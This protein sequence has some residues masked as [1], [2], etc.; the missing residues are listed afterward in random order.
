MMQ[1]QPANTSP[2]MQPTL[3]R[4][5]TDQADAQQVVG[6]LSDVM[7][8]LLQLVQEETHLVRLGRLTEVSRLAE[9]K[10]KLARL[11][12][13][14][15]ARLQASQ[16]YLAKTVPA[17][18]RILH[19]RHNTFRGMLQIN[20]TVLA[21]AHAVAEGIIRGVADEINKA[22]APQVYGAS[23]SRTAPSPRN[24]QPLAVSRVL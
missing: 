13:A 15:T 17:V 3:V 14:D 21:T 2:P 7:D 6:H 18:L 5:I 8:S 10:A 22:A 1:Q 19:E 24:A 20:L 23:G 4:P 9:K 16:P 11:Y 12:L